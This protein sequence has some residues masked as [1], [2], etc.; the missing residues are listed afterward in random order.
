[1]ET[2]NTKYIFS[3]W[4]CEFFQTTKQI[5]FLFKILWLVPKHFNLT[6]SNLYILDLKNILFNAAFL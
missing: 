4:E 3:E 6:K 5:K 2:T 1:M